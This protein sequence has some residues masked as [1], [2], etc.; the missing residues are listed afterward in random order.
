[1]T[2]K[3][4][5]QL[6]RETIEEVGTTNEM[7]GFG[8]GNS[9]LRAS[10]DAEVDAIESEKRNANATAQKLIGKTIKTINLDPKDGYMKISFNDG[11]SV[12]F[13]EADGVFSFEGTGVR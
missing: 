6:I 8:G 3:E 7:F 1:M 4:L 13:G 5:K 11:T 2:R 9:K 10:L 12:D